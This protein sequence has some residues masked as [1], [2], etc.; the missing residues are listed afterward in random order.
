MSL[1]PQQM[2]AT[3]EELQVNFALTGLTKTQVATGLN[4]SV[5][6]LDHLF[7]LTQQS[8]EDPWILRNYLID[9]VEAAG[10]TPVPF[11]ALS[12]DWHRHWFL[13]SAVIDRR[14]MSAGDR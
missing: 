12:G 2:R 10:K 8:L 9:Q 6:K 1:N 14:E 4:I 13:N 7:D 3:R 11:T 5:T